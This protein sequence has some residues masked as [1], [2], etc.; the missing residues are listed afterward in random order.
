ME[1]PTIYP[2]TKSGESV[3]SD[4]R[5]SLVVHR[6]KLNLEDAGVYESTLVRKGKPDY[7]QLYECRE[8]DGYKAGTLAYAQNKDQTI[9]VYERN[10]NVTIFMKSSHPSP[11]T[12]VSMNWEGDYNPRFYKR[13]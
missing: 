12:L 2:Q 1:F 10:T 8:Q 13:V 7:T 9:P 6:I 3:R 4:V 5:S 11:A